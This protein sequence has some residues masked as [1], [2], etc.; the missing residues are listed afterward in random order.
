MKKFNLHWKRGSVETITGNTI[1]EAFRDAGYSG[2]ALSS[3]D[4]YEE[5]REVPMQHR[6]IILIENRLQ[7]VIGHGTLFAKQLM[8]QLK[9]DTNR[10][11]IAI[12]N[13][14]WICDV[15]ITP[16]KIT[17]NCIERKQSGKVVYKAAFA[18]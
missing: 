11:V 15:S 2:G 1:D 17:C 18:I 5:A 16:F 14:K 6:D 3:L 8:E 4:Y 7:V 13:H 12:M 10:V 9:N